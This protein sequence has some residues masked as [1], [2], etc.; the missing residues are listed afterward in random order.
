MMFD[1]FIV[2]SDFIFFYSEQTKAFIKRVMI[3][4]N[5]RL[6]GKFSIPNFH[7]IT[8]VNSQTLNNNSLIENM[9]DEQMSEIPMLR[10]SSFMNIH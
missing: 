6:A 4:I 7:S 5:D 3:I 1:N 9:F 2:Q 10:Q 8:D